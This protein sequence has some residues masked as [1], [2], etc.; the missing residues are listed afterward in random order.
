MVIPLLANQDL[1]PM[2]LRVHVQDF[3]GPVLKLS[4]LSRDFNIKTFLRLGRR[5]DSRARG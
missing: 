3:F 1:T 4:Q 5:V 2:L